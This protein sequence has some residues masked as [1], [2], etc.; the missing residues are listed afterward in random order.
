A[1]VLSQDQTLHKSFLLVKSPK[2]AKNKRQTNHPK[3]DQPGIHYPKNTRT[4]PDRV[5]EQAHAKKVDKR[6]TR[7]SW[8]SPKST[9]KIV[10]RHT[11][12]FSK[13]TRTLSPPDLA[14]PC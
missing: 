7:N 2:P 9:Q 12:E 8:H 4:H 3:G 11:I 5:K 6:A 10:H 1:F 13:N 14:R